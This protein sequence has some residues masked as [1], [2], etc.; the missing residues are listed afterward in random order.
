MRHSHNLPLPPRIYPVLYKVTLPESTSS[1]Q[2]IP[3][4][5]TTICDVPRIYPALQE[6]TP[7]SQNIG[8][9][10]PLRYVTLPEYTH[11]SRIYPLL[12]HYMRT[13]IIYPSL[14]EYTH[15]LNMYMRHSQYPHS[16]PKYTPFQT[17]FCIRRNETK[18]TIRNWRNWLSVI[19]E[20][21]LKKRNWFPVIDETEFR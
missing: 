5:S 1:F 2:N 17:A 18:Q 21:K 15:P 10:P 20:T 9:P 13:P 3:P 4:F 6:S 11:P 16:N 8:L 12:R 7:P 19:D 14:P